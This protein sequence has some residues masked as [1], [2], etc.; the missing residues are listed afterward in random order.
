LRGTSAKN[1]IAIGTATTSRLLGPTSKPISR[2]TT[3][4]ERG[5][6]ERVPPRER[7]ARTGQSEHGRSE[8]P[9]RSIAITNPGIAS[10]AIVRH[11]ARSSLAWIVYAASN[12]R[13]ERKTARSSPCE[14]ILGVLRDEPSVSPD[15]AA[16][17]I[18]T[19]LAD[20][21]DTVS[22]FPITPCSG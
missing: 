16:D 9:V 12:T 5:E 10:V 11:L 15:P 2:R 8:R 6:N 13:P 14:V 22:L 1:A 21:T 18:V 7:Q 3:G 19:A 17:V 20:S 4:Q